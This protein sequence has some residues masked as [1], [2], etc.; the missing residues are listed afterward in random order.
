MLVCL[1]QDQT[2]ALVVEMERKGEI[3]EIF[4]RSN[5]Q[6]C[7][8]QLR[9][10]ECQVQCVGFLLVELGDI[11]FVFITVSERSNVAVLYSWAK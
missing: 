7:T 10:K 5:S 1:L 8:W 2:R 3:E 9:E 6:C 11:W 4:R